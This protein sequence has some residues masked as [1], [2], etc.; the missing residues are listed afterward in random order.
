MKQ[1]EFGKING[2]D[3]LNALYYF[4]GVLLLNGTALLSVGIVPTLPQIMALLG[5][6]LSAGL[7]NIFKNFYKGEN[8]QY[9]KKEKHVES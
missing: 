3:L 6:S 7:L 1:S 4:L 2:T 9:A 8:G 5:A